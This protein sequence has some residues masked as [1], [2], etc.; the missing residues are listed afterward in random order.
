MLK[1][2]RYLF[3]MAATFVAIFSICFALWVIVGACIGF[4]WTV[5]KAL[6]GII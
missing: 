5:G 4:G 3:S 1:Q 6:A 2:I